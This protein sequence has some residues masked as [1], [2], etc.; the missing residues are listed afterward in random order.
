MVGVFDALITSTLDPFP[1]KVI[2]GLLLF[3][4]QDQPTSPR[5]VIRRIGTNYPKDPDSPFYDASGKEMK[6]LARLNITRQRLYEKSCDANGAGNFPTFPTQIKF[7]TRKFTFS[8]KREYITATGS[9]W[10]FANTNGGFRTRVSQIYDRVRFYSNRSVRNAKI[11]RNPVSHCT[12]ATLVYI[13]FH[14]SRCILCIFW[15]QASCSTLM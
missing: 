8:I 9:G 15:V 12:Y 2:L 14:T 11:H 3:Q 1:F 6:P 5:E 4:S 13:S 7:H 10:R